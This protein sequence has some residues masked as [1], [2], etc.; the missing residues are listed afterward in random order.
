MQDVGAWVFS[1][2]TTNAALVALLGD[3]SHI[4][5]SYPDEVTVF[6]LVIFRESNQPDALY[7][8]NKPI[9]NES[10]FTID[11]FVRDDTPTPIAMAVCDI[12]KTSLWACQYNEDSPDTETMVRHRVMRFYRPIFPGDLV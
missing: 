4:V 8:D 5:T 2:L 3:D 9:A 12:F 1:K 6:P 7:N 11:V 10:T